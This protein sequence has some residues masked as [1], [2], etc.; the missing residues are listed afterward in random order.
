MI[1]CCYLCQNIFEEWVGGECMAGDTETGAELCNKWIGNE[2]KSYLCY[3]HNKMWDLRLGIINDWIHR[4]C[5]DTLLQSD[6][7]S[8]LSNG[9]LQSNPPPM[10]VP[11]RVHSCL[12]S[13]NSKGPPLS[14][15]QGSPPNLPTFVSMS[16]EWRL[17][18]FTVM[19]NWIRNSDCWLSKE[20]SVDPHP[21]IVKDKQE[22]AL[23]V[24]QGYREH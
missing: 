18:L 1:H 23:Q 6:V 21:M 2:P 20:N 24:V 8:F 17:E 14:P 10:R 19:S 12:L 11:T 7:L 22:T 16:R 4:T 13:L 9:W 3:I 5:T 15:L